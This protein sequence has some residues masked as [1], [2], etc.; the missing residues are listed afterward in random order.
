MVAAAVM[1]AALGLAAAALGTAA[2]TA[3]AAL[4]GAALHVERTGCNALF[5]TH[6]PETRLLLHLEPTFQK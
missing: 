4:T 6:D 5:E 1:A 3:A 2:A